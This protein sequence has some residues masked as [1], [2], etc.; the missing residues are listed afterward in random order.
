MMQHCFS[1]QETAEKKKN[2]RISETFENIFRAADTGQHAQRWSQQR[3]DRQR[4]RF[5]DPQH[6]NQTQGGKKFV[7]GWRE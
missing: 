3:G 4:Q 6:D 5:R 2:D 7:R 1:E